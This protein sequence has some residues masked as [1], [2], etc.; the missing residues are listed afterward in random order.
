MLY[1]NKIINKSEIY[2]FMKKFFLLMLAIA[3]SSTTVS[4]QEE[5]PDGW[6]KGGEGILNFSQTNLRNWAEGG[7][8]STAA[9]ANLA[10]FADYKK[11][12]VTWENDLR[13]VLGMIG[14]NNPTDPD[15]KTVFRKADDVIDFDSKVGYKLSDKVFWSTLLEFDSQIAKGFNYDDAAQPIIS[16]FAAPAYLRFGTGIDYKPY[17][18]LSVYFSPLTYKAIIVA[19][20]EIA[21]LGL[22]GLPNGDQFKSEAGAYLK[23]GFKKD[24]IKNVSYTSNLELFSNYL[25][26][27]FAEKRDNITVTETAINGTE[28]VE[29]KNGVYV[30]STEGKSKPQNVDVFWINT[31]GFKVNK[32]ITATFEATLKY[33]REVDV[34]SNNTGVDAAGNT[35]QV[36]DQGIQLKNFIGIGFTYKF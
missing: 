7:V 20:E 28:T 12:K 3:M 6:K 9:T 27:N 25:A 31:F 14:T 10:V 1:I 5:T 22:Y 24:L 16:R 2:N 8:N 26:T 19:D 21:N 11:D 34:N 13:L 36:I 32:Y 4:A 15:D 35:V 30:L 17:E 33:D 29:T 18:F 23:V